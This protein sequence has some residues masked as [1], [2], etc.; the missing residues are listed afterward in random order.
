M[1]K[2]HLFR[3]YLFMIRFYGVKRFEVFSVIND[4]SSFPTLSMIEFYMDKARKI[5]IVS[6]NRLLKKNMKNIDNFFVVI[7]DSKI[8]VHIAYNEK[9]GLI[10]YDF[11]HCMN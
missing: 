1:E 3:I 4:Q 6:L 8:I 10:D 9:K 7:E 11:E 2:V 5:N